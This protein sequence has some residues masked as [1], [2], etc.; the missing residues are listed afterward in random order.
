MDPLDLDQLSFSGHTLNV[1]ER[2]GLEVAITTRRLAD[3]L[4]E[5]QFWGKITGADADYLIVSGFPPSQDFP[6]KLFFYCTSKDFTLV[7]FPKVS[8]EFAAAAGAVKGPFKGTPAALLNEDD[9]EDEDEVD[10]DGNPMPKAEKLR[11]AHRL[12]V[13]VAAIDAEVS[14]VPRGAYVV[15]ATHYVIRNA[16]FGGLTP[17]EAADLSNYFHFREP[18]E[19]GR[20]SVLE[21]RGLVA[22]TDFLDPIAE[23]SPRGVWAVRVDKARGQASLRSLVWPGYFF[24]HNTQSSRFG[25]AYFGNGQRNNDIGYMI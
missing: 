13:T 18:V 19:L 10:E 15:N 11:E 16:A 7:P 14:V 6:H 8:E 22:S 12:A 4:A 21:R 17:T 1:E 25:G 20:K 24:F 3:G 2:S 5:A 23:D 9:E